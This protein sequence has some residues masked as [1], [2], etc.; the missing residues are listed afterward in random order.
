MSLRFI[1]GR[2]GAGKTKL[3]FEEARNTLKKN[4]DGPPLIY[5]VPDQMTFDTEYAMAKTPG[6]KGMTRFHVYSFSRLAMRVLQQA[7]GMTRYHLN[8]TGMMMLIRKIIEHHKD[9]LRVFQKASEQKGFYDVLHTA[10][11]EFKQ[12][13]LTPGDLFR[14]YQRLEKE[15]GDSGETLLKDKLYDMQFIYTQLD[16][17]LLNKYIDSEDYLR[18]FIEKAGQTTFFQDAEVWVDGFDSFTPHEIEALV[19]LMKQA[20]Q[21]T[22]TLTVDQ[23]YDSYYPGELSL[24]RKTGQTYRQI[25]EAAK[26]H[27]IDIQNP[28]ILNETVRFNEP[29]LSHLEKHYE[30]R[31]AVESYSGQAVYLSEAVNRREEIEQAA[32]DVLALARDEGLRFRDIALLVRDLSVYRELIETIFKD[33]QIPVFIDQKRPMRHHPLIEFIRSALDVI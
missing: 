17:A 2:A 7:G 11:T 25:K 28:V 5:L 22:I 29:A 10:I 1:L 3:C 15:A 16:Q 6:L 30:T 27:V 12:Y 14:K 9:E 13:C 4:P 23:A 31:P 20:N 24:F 18:L 8:Q 19:Q 26:E 33:Y 21:V 32:R